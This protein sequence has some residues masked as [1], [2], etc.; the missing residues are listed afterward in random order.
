MTKAP[1]KAGS[2][3]P[4]IV[5]RVL[6]SEGEP[7]AKPVRDRFEP[8]LGFSLARVRLHR[9]DA[10]AESAEAVGANA[11][12]VGHHV[13]LSRGMDDIR[14]LAHE[15]GHVAQQRHVRSF[16]SPLPI[17]RSD[18][19]TEHDAG[20]TAHRLLRGEAASTRPLARA[21]LARDPSKDI[22]PWYGPSA[23]QR[24]LDSPS[25]TANAPARVE[26]LKLAALT[27]EPSVAAT[28][29]AELHTGRSH[30]AQRFSRLAPRSQRDILTILDMRAATPTTAPVAATPGPSKAIHEG[31]RTRVAY[32]TTS[33]RGGRR[34]ARDRHRTQ[35][36]S[37]VNKTTLTPTTISRRSLAKSFRTMRS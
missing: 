25:T 18:S 2:I 34:P 37:Q 11:Y 21:E 9:G 26:A 15:L 22:Y 1:V 28:L 14:L 6:R 13:V 10:A 31:P 20:R 16:G 23:I 4:A 27:L 32:Q 3:A 24:I 17:A 7:L 35:P 33:I 8:H 30:T 5:H 12:T 19:A 29:R 36:V